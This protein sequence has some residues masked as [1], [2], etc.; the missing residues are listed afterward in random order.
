M[1]GQ[2]T[3]PRIE[4]AFAENATACT[5]AAP[6][7]GG[8]TSPFPVTSQIGIINGAAS[9]DDGFPPLTDTPTTSGG[10][11]PFG[12]DFN[13]I[14]YLLSAHIAAIAAGQPYL[15]DATL[16]AF[17]SG[18]AKGAILQQSADPTALWIN[19]VSGNASNPDTGTPGT[20]GWISSKPLNKVSTPAAGTFN[21]NVLP[22][23]SDYIYDYN[24][25]ASGGNVNLTGFVAQ[26]DG[27][28]L[29][30]RKTDSSA[31]VLTL[32]SLTGS[33]AG[34]QLQIVA[35]GIA[36]SLQYMAVT[37]RWNSTVNAWVQE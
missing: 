12:I 34:N 21:D 31:N 13:G 4:T 3:P 23:P 8:K 27:Q 19:D 10:T 5:Q 9:L 18:Y 20:A 36:L 24:L 6:V 14:F 37:I 32:E 26:R 11:P 22:G 16:A 30:I 35:A 33:A 15:F 28:R 29:T 2:P 7:T 17:M 25:A 1:P